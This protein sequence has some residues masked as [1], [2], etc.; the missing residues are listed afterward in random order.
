V[1]GSGGVRTTYFNWMAE[2]ARLDLRL[3]GRQARHQ[4]GTVRI[5]GSDPALTRLK[6]FPSN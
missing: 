1:A 6:M 4:D 3:A 5:S 2:L